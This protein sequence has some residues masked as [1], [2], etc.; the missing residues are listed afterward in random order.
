MLRTEKIPVI[1]LSLIT[2]FYSFIVLSALMKIHVINE[3]VLN[4]NDID[5]II[6]AWAFTIFYLV[7]HSSITFWT[8]RG[9]KI[10]MKNKKRQVNLN[11]LWEQ[12]NKKSVQIPMSLIVYF[13]AWPDL[14][15]SVLTLP[16]SF[17][18]CFLSALIS[19]YCLNRPNFIKSMHCEIT[20]YLKKEIYH[21]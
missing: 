19:S 11:R 13:A 5:F 10:S 1:K 4:V 17:G 9:Y 6:M 16:F 15:S 18:L 3:S 7:F 8:L 21:K 14:H 12:F 2:V 20:N